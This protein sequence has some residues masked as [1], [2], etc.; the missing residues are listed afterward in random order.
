[1]P[2]LHAF[3]RYKYDK[4]KKEVYYDE[5]ERSDVVIY[6]KEWLKRMFEYQKFMKEFDS[7][8]MDIVLESQLKLEE[9]N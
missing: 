9:K 2:K 3:V 5:H 1:M 7:D 6:R 8:T 4:R